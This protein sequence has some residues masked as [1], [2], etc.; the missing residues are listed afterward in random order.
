MAI[1]D[2]NCGSRLEGSLRPDYPYPPAT[3]GTRWSPLQ[4][5]IRASNLLA[6]RIGCARLRSSVASLHGAC[7]PRVDTLL[8]KSAAHPTNASPPPRGAALP[9]MRLWQRDLDIDEGRKNGGGSYKPTKKLTLNKISPITRAMNMAA[10]NKEPAHHG[11]P[12]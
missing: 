9:P 6:Y 2:G 1:G 12:K 5:E 11:L 8:D 7:S 3:M 4:S 10:S